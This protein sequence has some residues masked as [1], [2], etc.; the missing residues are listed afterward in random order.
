[1]A[2][3]LPNIKEFMNWNWEQFSPYYQQ[4][5]DAQLDEGNVDKWLDDW[6]HIRELFYERYNRHYT[7]VTLNTKDREAEE[8]YKNFLDKIFAPVQKE[9]NLLKEKLLLS[10][11]EPDGLEEQ[12]RAI[13]AEADLFR[14]NNL[15]L[16]AEDL[17]F[18]NEYDK[19]IG[20]QT[21]EWEGEEV[22]IPKLQPV[23]QETDRDKREKAWRLASQR[24]L[25]DR[26]KINQLWGQFMNLRRELA[27]NAGK[28]NYRDY[29][30]QQLLRFYYSPED[31]QQFHN[32]IESVVV[33][34]AEKIYE[35]R[36]RRIGADTLRP[37][38][39]DVDPWGR[40]PLK[41]FKEVSELISTT[42]NIFDQVDSKLG[43]YFKVM[44][45]KA[46]LD[47]DNRKGKAPGGYCIDFPAEKV[48]FIFMNSVGIHDDVQT[49][50]HEGGH[51]FHVFETASL[52][53]HHQR[54]I[55]TEIAEIASMSMELLA[56][57]YISQHTGGFYNEKDAARA[58]TEHLSQMIL[59]WPYMAVVDTF[60]HWVYENHEDARIPENC[61]RKWA[62]LWR[63]FMKGVDWSGLEDALETGW[64]RK[65]H[66][67]QVPFYYIDYGLAQLG[68][69]QIWRNAMED[70][71]GAVD[72][73]R[74][75][76][77]LGATRPLPELFRAA[78]AKLS[79]DEATL[80]EAVDLVEKKMEELEA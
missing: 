72:A 45:E 32:A 15:P 61:D 41:P 40:E 2:D 16:L 28:E 68:A 63:R 34:A 29:R 55:G 60:Q 5:A 9:E 14:E 78:G 38:D 24:Q 10:N 52:P 3:K 56:S 26:E 67:H 39:L 62:E 1:M 53:Y 51:A 64:H 58:R 80:K 54:Q 31:C 69:I 25:V 11:L 35:N 6:S 50:I 4:L 79:F 48:P 20:S 22:T 66:I 37:W 42:Q 57:P 27:V 21:V 36:R 7:A 77:S 73:Y 13:R 59:F 65:L 19:I 18:A 46:L 74:R 71:A 33:P 12:M 49:L 30:W 44:R 76:L 17:K 23:Y 43:E 47:L 70:Q 75:A 8:E